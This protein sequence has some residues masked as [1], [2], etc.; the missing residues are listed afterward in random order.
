MAHMWIDPSG[1]SLVG[2]GNGV[3]VYYTPGSPVPS[4]TTKLWDGSVWRSATDAGVWDGTVWA[5]L[6]GSR[7]WDG[8]GWVVV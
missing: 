7:V 1:V 8:S 5:P 4:T 3:G 2:V 6:A